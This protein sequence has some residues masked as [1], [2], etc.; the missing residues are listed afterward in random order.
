MRESGQRPWG[1]QRTSQFVYLLFHHIGMYGEKICRGQSNVYAQAISLSGC[2]LP[3][4][5]L[6]IPW[7]K[8]SSEEFRET[9]VR[10]ITSEHGGGNKHCFLGKGGNKRPSFVNIAVS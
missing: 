1:R 10:F 5:C 3:F 9:V 6:S 7:T 2:S 8:C 4:L